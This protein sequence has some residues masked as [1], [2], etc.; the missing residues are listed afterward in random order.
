MRAYEVRQFGGP[1]VLELGAQPDPR[2]GA[3][4]VIVEVRAV[5]LNPIDLL[6]LS[7]AFRLANPP[8]FPFVPGN[9]FAGVVS[10]VG[11]AVQSFAIGDAVIGR[12]N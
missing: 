10:A 3:G 7:G 2:I 12:T 5:G 11:A 4:D 1:E 9:G 8:R 6:Q